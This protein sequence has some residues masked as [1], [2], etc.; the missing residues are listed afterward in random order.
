M[1]DDDGLFVNLFNDD[2]TFDVL[3]MSN[4][5]LLVVD[6]MGV[7]VAFVVDVIVSMDMSL[8]VNVI[9]TVQVSVFASLSVKVGS[10]VNSS[11]LTEC[12]GVGDN[13]LGGVGSLD[14]ASS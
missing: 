1:R 3:R 13:V 4:G 9:S 2:G 5:E 12:V 11:S 10:S 6:T 14:E 8:R 7:G